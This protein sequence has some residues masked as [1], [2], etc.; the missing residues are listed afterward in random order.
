MI[1][2]N[3][4]RIVM[5]TFLAVMCGFITAQADRDVRGVDAAFVSTGEALHSQTGAIIE[6]PILVSTSKSISGLQI[7]LEYDNE[8][9]RA[10]TPATTD[11]TRGMSIAHNADKGHIIILMYNVSGKTIDPGNGPVLTIPFTLSH[12]ARGECELKFQQVILADEEAQAIPSEV[13]SVPVAI[14][15]TLPTTYALSQN[16]PNPFNPETVIDFQLPQ[17]SHVNLTIF[18]MLGQEIRR[19]MDEKKSGGYYKVVWDG[20]SEVG[21]SVASGVYFY[22]LKA[23]HFSSIKKMMLLK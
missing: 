6:I 4:Y 3:N 14:H 20:K 2:K 18:N 8:M 22:S 1:S 16:Y 10:G 7:S 12:E 19:L 5:V 17:E 21:E 23:G 13:K 9:M 11:R 15:N